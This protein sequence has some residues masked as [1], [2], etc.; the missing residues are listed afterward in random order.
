MTDQ[1]YIFIYEDASAQKEIPD[2]TIKINNI[3]LF[4]I[5]IKSKNNL[6]KMSDNNLVLNKSYCEK[7]ECYL[8]LIY[9]LKYKYFCIPHILHNYQ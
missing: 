7:S 2:F 1:Y 9:L 5:K 3:V 4:N 8:V 6:N